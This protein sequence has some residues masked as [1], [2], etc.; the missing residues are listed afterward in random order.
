M[1]RSLVWLVPL[2]LGPVA[3]AAEQTD[4]LLHRQAPGRTFGYDADT[5]NRDDSGQPSGQFVADRFELAAAGAVCRVRWWSFYGSSLAQE[6]EPPPAHET[7]RVRFYGDRSG[8]P[9]DLLR[10][11]TFFDPPRQATGVSIPTGVGPLE[12]VYNVDLPVCLPAQSGT[13]YWLEI[14]QLGDIDSRF[15]WEASNNGEF[16][17]RFPIDTPYRLINNLGQLSYE[18][19]TPE[20]C[21]G[22]L[23]GLALAYLLNRRAR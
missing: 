17:V 18:L 4:I 10:E 15:R 5:L 19:R 20:P 3:L 16:A 13:T 7:I 6:L 12:Y 8:L 23:L 21:S 22:A 1:R 9:G 2:L 14:A 11:F